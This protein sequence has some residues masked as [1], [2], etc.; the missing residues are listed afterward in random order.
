MRPMVLGRK[1]TPMIAPAPIRTT[2]MTDARS[3]ALRPNDKGNRPAELTR[4][5]DQGMCRRVRL[6]ARLGPQIAAYGLR[7]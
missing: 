1:K 7:R 5:D 6:T 3:T 2:Q 4:T